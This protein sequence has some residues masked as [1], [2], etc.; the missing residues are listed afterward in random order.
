VH[1]REHD[2]AV[3]ALR[4]V[5]ARADELPGR[6]GDRDGARGREALGARHIVDRPPDRH[7]LP[8]IADPAY[9]GDL[10]RPRADAG[11]SLE[12][13]HGGPLRI[14]QSGLN[15]EPR[16]GCAHDRVGQPI[17]GLHGPVG[18]EG[19]AG[20]RQDVAAVAVDEADQVGEVRVKVANEV[21][22]TGGVRRRDL[23]DV[24]REAR[25]V[26]EQQRS[27]DAGRLE[28]PDRSRDRQA[29]GEQARH[30]ARHVM[31]GR[32]GAFYDSVVKHGA[33]PLSTHG[34]TL[35]LCESARGKWSRSASG[36]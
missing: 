29:I 4:P 31:R 26:G 28:L 23:L 15:G 13:V 10:Q 9:E 14:A 34:A 25:D 19:V 3:V 1:A 20:D 33:I 2:D 8:A 30:V 35:L 11:T 12:P 21:L 18:E 24:R 7:E 5:A 22:Q 17:L 32:R 36:D 6:R 16:L 27:K